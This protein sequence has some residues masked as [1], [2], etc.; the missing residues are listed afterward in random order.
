MTTTFAWASYGQNEVS[1][2]MLVVMGTGVSGCNVVR[3]RKKFHLADLD[4]AGARHPSKHVTTSCRRLEGY[5]L[6]IERKKMPSLFI[7]STRFFMLSFMLN[8][9]D[10]AHMW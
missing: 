6:P 2:E 7:E 1:G 4:V 9:S 10:M 8:R 3:E 5:G